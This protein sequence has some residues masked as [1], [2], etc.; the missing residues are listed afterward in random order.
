[1]KVL[2]AIDSFKGC[3]TSEEAAG[4]IADALKDEETEILPVS[5]GG[6]GFCPIVTGALGGRMVK[7]EVHDPLGRP[8]S[9]EYGLIGDTAI[10]ESASASGLTLMSPGE[11]DPLRASSRGTGEMIRDAVSRGAREI[12]LGLGGTGTNDGGTGLLDAIQ[13]VDLSCCHIYALCDVNATFC[14]PEGASALYGP[15]KGAGPGQVAMLDERLRVLAGEYLRLSGRDVLT[16]PGSGAAGGIG[17]AVWAMLGGELIPG[18][19]AVLKILDFDSKLEGVSLVITGEGKMDAQTMQGKLPYT[20][21]T[22]AKALRPDIKVA[23]FTGRDEI[24]GEGCPF[25]KIVQI[26]PDGTPPELALSKPFASRRL[27]ECVEALQL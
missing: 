20:V 2:I 5:D 13:D 10:I 16:M 18:A 6:E 25:D 22:R 1:M 8:I 15:Q 23:A 7:A 3:L 21:A 26:T 19:E 17:G 24:G 9:A 12:Y 11:L 4:I 14:G 27:R